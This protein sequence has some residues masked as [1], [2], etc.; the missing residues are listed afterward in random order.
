MSLPTLDW[1]LLAILLISLLV[2]LWRGIVYE[3]ISLASWVVA[4]VLAQ[5]FAA[6]VAARLPMAGAAEPVR[7]A[8]GFVLVF[9]VSLVA[10]GL[11]AF[12]A[13]K[14]FAAVGL[15]VLDRLL[16][17]GFGL[18]RGVVLVLALTMVVHMTPMASA[19]FW[20]ESQGARWAEAT[21]SALGPL[22]PPE[23]GKYLS[24]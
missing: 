3:A 8:A 1:I 18:L 2:G 14:L 6:D 4:F 12:I 10:G 13:K 7:Y 17:G 5:W 11:L 19:A 21:L 15:G 24:T 22:M 20:Q 16:G 23:L 9:V